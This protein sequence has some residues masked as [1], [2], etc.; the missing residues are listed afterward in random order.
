MTATRTDSPFSCQTHRAHCTSTAT[1]SANQRAPLTG[2]THPSTR[3]RPPARQ[4]CRPRSTARPG[5]RISWRWKQQLGRIAD[6]KRDGGLLCFCKSLSL[7][8]LREESG[9]ESGIRTHGR[10]F[11]PTHAFQACSFNHSDISP[12]REAADSLAAR[13]RPTVPRRRRGCC[14]GRSSPRGRRTRRAGRRSASSAARSA[15]AASIPWDR[16]R[17][18]R[19]AASTPRPA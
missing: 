6:R 15:T 3:S 9:G 1:F 7:N 11:T 5:Q 4:R 13:A 14:T 2:A 12:V 16:P 19:T 17:S 10:R 8:H 18:P